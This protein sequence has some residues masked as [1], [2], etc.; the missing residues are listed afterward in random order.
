MPD[1]GTVGGQ[2]ST[3]SVVIFVIA[4]CIVVALAWGARGRSPRP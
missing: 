4:I 3:P 2:M 1:A